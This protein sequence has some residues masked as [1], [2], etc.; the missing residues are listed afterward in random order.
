MK[1]FPATFN[2]AT[3]DIDL[4]Y[5]PAQAA[6]EQM[7]RKLSHQADEAIAQAIRKRCNLAADLHGQALLEA[8]KGHE[9]TL[10]R[11]YG[12]N[13]YYLDGQFLVG[14][15]IRPI[16]KLGHLAAEIIIYHGE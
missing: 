15:R 4:D 7:G 10:I 12:M 8:I 6:I 2:L 3:V 1:G 13:A 11:R 16:D 5:T 9:F 14:T